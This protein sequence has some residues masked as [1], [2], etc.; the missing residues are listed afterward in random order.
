MHNWFSSIKSKLGSAKEQL[1]PTVDES[2]ETVAPSIPIVPAGGPT[3]FTITPSGSI[4]FSGAPSQVHEHQISPSG[5][6][7]FSG[8]APVIDTN[9]YQITP[10]G[11]I[12]FSGTPDQIHEKII[13]AG[14]TITFNGTGGVIYLPAG[15][16]GASD[17]Q[18]I[19][20]GLGRAGRLG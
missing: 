8:T 4:A 12:V 20:I 6:V 3:T 18:R 14:G 7:I 1:A 17:Y 9:T 19:S 11:E 13:A 2:Q 15:G 16:S 10:S 5:S